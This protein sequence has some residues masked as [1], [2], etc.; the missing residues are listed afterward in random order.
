[1]C[2]TEDWSHSKNAL[3]GRLNEND[4]GK[5]SEI[6]LS[7]SIPPHLCV[8]YGCTIE[9]AWTIIKKQPHGVHPAA[10]LRLQLLCILL[11]PM[12]SAGLN[13]FIPIQLVFL[14]TMR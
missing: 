1:M 8:S 11:H 10:H 4:G 6:S 13:T 7:S 9:Y 14:L 3:V 2:G 12:I 5:V